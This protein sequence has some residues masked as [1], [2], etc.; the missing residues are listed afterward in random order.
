LNG[1]VEQIS[2]CPLWF[3]EFLPQRTQRYTVGDSGIIDESFAVA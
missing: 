1:K 3:I 2:Q